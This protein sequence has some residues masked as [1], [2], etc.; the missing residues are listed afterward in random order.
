[1]EDQEREIKLYVQDLPALA[2]RLRV[3]GAE[4]VRERM[5]ERNFRLDTADNELKKGGRL[6]RLRE[7]DQVRVTYKDRTRL[8]EGVVTRREIEFAADDLEAVRKLFEALG[9][10]VIVTYEK[11]RAVFRMGDVKIMLDEL[12]Y[13]DFVEVEAPNNTL[14]QGVV[15]MLGLDASKAVNTNYLGLFERLQM[16]R[17]LKIDDLTF[18][19]FSNVIV[20]AADMAVEPADMR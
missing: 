3:S 10:Q 14:I 13:G 18:D 11:Y 19:R 8:S 4:K 9:Y 5:L 12:P 2:E 15:Q 7:D 6:L 17:N 16:S 20:S 1:M